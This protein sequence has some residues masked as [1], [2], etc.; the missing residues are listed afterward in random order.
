MRSRCFKRDGR[1]LFD[2]LRLPSSLQPYMG[3]PRVIGRELRDAG[4]TPAELRRWCGGF[5]YLGDAMRLFPVSTCWAMG[6]S[7]SS[8][9]AQCLTLNGVC[10]Q[11]GLLTSAVLSTSRATPL[12]LAETFAVAT[13]DVMVFSR[14][15]VPRRGPPGP[16]LDAA[17]VS[18]GV[19]KKR[20]EGL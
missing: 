5:R 15:P 10:R 12:C 17:M 9:I 11:A 3:R 16:R 8:F 20:Q 6:F 7:W 19:V 14:G 1:C 13:D 2:Q 4:A 18:L